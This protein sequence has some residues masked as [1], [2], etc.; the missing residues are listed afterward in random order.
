MYID[1]TTDE[2]SLV[3]RLIREHMGNCTRISID[4]TEPFYRVVIGIGDMRQL[5]DASADPEG[6]Q[7]VHVRADEPPPVLRRT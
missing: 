5:D 4:R 1:I 3:E 2:P 6:G 7:S